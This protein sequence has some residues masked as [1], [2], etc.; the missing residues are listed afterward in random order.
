MHFLRAKQWLL[1]P[2]R[3]FC[4]TRQLHPSKSL[5]YSFGIDQ[6]QC[7]YLDDKYLPQYITFDPIANFV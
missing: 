7:H 6:S 2:H 5:V 1:L 4:L 3:G